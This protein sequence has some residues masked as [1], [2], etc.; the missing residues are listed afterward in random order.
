MVMAPPHWLSKLMDLT[1]MSWGYSM[2]VI[3]LGV[4]YSL[5]AWIFDK[6]FAMPMARWLGVAKQSLTGKA[7]RRK[8]YKA[9]REEIRRA[10]Q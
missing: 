6:H 5:M 7:K 2:F 9:I 3:E 4:M 8:Q 1:Y 10:Q